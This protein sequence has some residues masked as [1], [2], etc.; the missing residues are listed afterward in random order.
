MRAYSN[1]PIQSKLQLIVAVTVA[2]AVW[3]TVCWE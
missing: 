3:L 1:L 2:V